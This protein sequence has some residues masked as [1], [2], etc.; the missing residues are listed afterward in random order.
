MTM[1]RA[2]R[3]AAPTV[4]ADDPAA[5]LIVALD[6]DD[7]EGA[8]R[9]ARTLSGVVRRVKVG[10]VLFTAAGPEA[11]LW[12]QRLGF[13]VFLDLKFHDIP[14]TVEKSVRAAVHHGVWMLTVHASGQPAMLEAAARG[15][16]EEAAA[17]GRPRP[18]VVG[19]TVLTS[20]EAG[21]RQA[22]A[23]Q[24]VAL[25]EQAK[26]AGLDG[27]VSSPQEAAA[28][29]RRVGRG[30]AIV[31]PGIRP[32]QGPSGDQQRVATPREALA[33]GAS[34]LVVGR[35]I[36]AAPDPADSA[37]NILAQMSLEPMTVKHMSKADPR[38][39][40]RRGPTGRQRKDR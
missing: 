39:T 32:A 13:D 5:R 17:T 33:A 27:V 4:D 22:T 30:V 34:Y 3:K 11:V 25:A 36:L 10:S 28:I 15:A 20:V 31:C 7:L 14:S 2:V 19:V 21:P 16:R 29:R 40:A 23:R 26:R 24:V 12:M 1:A 9:V 37:R 18:L 6:V 35:P 38:R 8:I